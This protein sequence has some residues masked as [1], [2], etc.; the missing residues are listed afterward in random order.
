MDIQ[1]Y[2][3][4]EVNVFRVE[5]GVLLPKTHKEYNDY[6]QVYGGKN[7][8]YDE[9][10][11]L[12]MTKEDAICYAKYKVATGVTN[13]YAIV[14]DEIINT[15]NEV[16]EEIKMSG[17]SFDIDMDDFTFDG[18]NVVFSLV[19]TENE[20]IENFLNKTILK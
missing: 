8:Y 2:G 3:T 4:R 18:T 11:V 14:V 5:L 9:N 7:A 1:F 17:W 13:T 10:E 12:F 20:Q 15:N 19:K 6:N 16:V